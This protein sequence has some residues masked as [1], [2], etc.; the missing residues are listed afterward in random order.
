[1]SEPQGNGP[2]AGAPEPQTPP[3]GTPDQFD[4]EKAWNLIQGL[5]ADKDKLAGRPA[6]TDEQ[7]AKLAEYDTLI[8]ASKSDAQ[9]KDEELSRWQT[10]AQQ[11]RA[12]AVAARVE[13]LAS[14]DFA[15]PSD[16]V[17][18]VDPAQYLTAGGEIDEDAIKRDLAQVLERKPHWRR[19]PDGPPAPRV[20]APNPAQGSG[21]GTA[22]AANPAAEF[23]ATIQGLLQGRQ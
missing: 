2:Q 10:D 9:R 17:G 4:P 1:M 15:D 20:P 3:W 6:L 5:R 13:A 18:A 16:A 21:G 11:W 8:E 19:T 14:T 12:R 23:A 7:K 22:A